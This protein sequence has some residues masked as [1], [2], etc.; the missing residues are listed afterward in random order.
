[1]WG[2]VFSEV[3]DDGLNVDTCGYKYNTTVHFLY[4]VLV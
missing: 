4:H 2:E 1:M 3:I